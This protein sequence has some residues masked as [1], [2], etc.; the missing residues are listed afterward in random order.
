LLSIGWTSAARTKL[1][2]G[3]FAAGFPHPASA[4]AAHS[5]ANPLL[6]ALGER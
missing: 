3:D 1:F 4:N 5:N 6:L 2:S